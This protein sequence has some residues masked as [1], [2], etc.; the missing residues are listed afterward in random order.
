MRQSTL[1]GTK[2][3]SA[4]G[5]TAVVQAVR[6]GTITLR[7]G[8]SLGLQQGCELV[9]QKGGARIR[10]SSPPTLSSAT[11]KLIIGAPPQVGDVFSLERWTV[12]AEID[13]RLFL[14]SAGLPSLQDLRRIASAIRAAAKDWRWIEDPTDES[15]DA[16]VRFDGGGWELEQR[17]QSK[18]DP[19]RTV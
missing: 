14:P 7:G 6:E 1:L 18:V 12:P 19:A 11:A 8:V 5:V 4:G 3:S 17:N 2:L 15:P 9:G 13:T 10:V 16:I